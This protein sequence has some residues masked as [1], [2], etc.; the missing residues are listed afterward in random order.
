[1]TKGLSHLSLF[2]AAHYDLM[3]TGAEMGKVS[4]C[5]KVRDFVCIKYPLV[6]GDL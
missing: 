4:R 1:M 3:K 6:A 5:S 2:P